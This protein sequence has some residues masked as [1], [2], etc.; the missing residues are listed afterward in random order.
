MGSYS[1]I[2]IGVS[3]IPEIICKKVL[4]AKF[5][6]LQHFLRTYLNIDLLS[7]NI[8]IFLNDIK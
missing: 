3:N 7:S 8:F 4:N 5:G 2:P 1:T 6:A